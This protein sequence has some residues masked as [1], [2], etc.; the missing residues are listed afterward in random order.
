[1]K[2]ELITVIVPAYN[3]GENLRRAIESVSSQTYNNI[4]I[5]I[6]DD[7]STD[8]T[9]K[10]AEEYAKTDERIHVYTK[11]NGGEANSRNFGLSKACG[12]YI[13]FCDADDCMH[14]EYIEKM[15]RAICQNGAD[16][17]ICSWSNV[18]EKGN[19]MPWK[20]EEMSSQLMDSK[21]AQ[22]I[23][24][25]TFALEGFCWNKLFKTSKYRDN[26]IKYDEGRASYCDM[27]AN[28]EMICCSEKVAYISDKLYDYYQMPT[29]CVHTPNMKKHR[30]YVQVLEQVRQA[31]AK[32]GMAKEGESYLVYRL[33]RY[34]FELYKDRAN[35]TDELKELYCRAYL[36][37]L[38][39]PL[40]KKAK[41]IFGYNSPSPLK[42][43]LKALF[44]AHFFMCLKGKA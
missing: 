25:T 8:N 16:M 14:P 21:Q 41:I 26:G 3:P 13:A 36:K 42:E 37:W 34:L 23:F 7:G 24:L 35:M 38:R 6:I 27:L 30:D 1:M 10:I 31:A 19:P 9:G 15:Y 39:I 29:S 44:V 32:R 11:T 40:A 17:A 2:N 43:T 18:D 5:L 4:E 20:R 22:K 28:Y 33:N 12:K